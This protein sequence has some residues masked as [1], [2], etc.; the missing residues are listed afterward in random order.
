MAKKNY[1]VIRTGSY[2]KVG[3]VVELDVKELSARQAIMLKPYEKPVVKANDSKE[4]AA[5]K[6]E[7]VKLQAEVKALKDDV[8][9][10][11]AK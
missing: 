6:A 7:V 11:T 3:A 10:L 4:L 5:A 8:E 2:G 1:T 9:A